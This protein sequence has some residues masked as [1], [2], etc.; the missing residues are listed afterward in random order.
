MGEPVPFGGFLEDAIDER[1][2]GSIG[3]GSFEGCEDLFVVDEFL[4]VRG[5]RVIGQ[6][7]SGHGLFRSDRA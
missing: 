6:S 1:K 7:S 4:R 3:A 5:G 2:V